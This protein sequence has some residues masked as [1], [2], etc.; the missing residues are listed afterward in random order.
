MNKYQKLISKI[1]K[2]D[3]K[4]TLLHLVAQREG[5]ILRYK[6]IRN[7]YRKIFKKVKS[8]EHIKDFRNFNK[9]LEV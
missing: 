5:V 7:E 4:K 3:L 2:D 1:A 9:G 8:Y 6:P